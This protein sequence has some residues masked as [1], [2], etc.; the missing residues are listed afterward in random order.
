LKQEQTTK[1]EAKK[2]IVFIED[3]T[4][5]MREIK[6]N[7]RIIERDTPPKV[8]EVIKVWEDCMSRYGSGGTTCT[9]YCKGVLG[10]LIKSVELYRESRAKELGLE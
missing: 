3:N 6:E 9:E 7:F 2:Y 1:I 10:Y 4:C 5:P 8:G